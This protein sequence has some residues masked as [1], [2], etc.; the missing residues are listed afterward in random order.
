M[1]KDSMDKEKNKEERKE[2]K[3]VSC[4]NYQFKKKMYY[5]TQ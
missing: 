2:Q 5:K 3:V 1:D 4:S